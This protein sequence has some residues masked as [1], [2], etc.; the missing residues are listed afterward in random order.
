M[1]RCIYFSSAKMPPVLTSII[2]KFRRL[3]PVACAYVLRHIDILS[4]T[5]F[6]SLYHMPSKRHNAHL[7]CNLQPLDIHTVAQRS[8]QQRHQLDRSLSL[9]LSLHCEDDDP[10]ASRPDPGPRQPTLLQE[11]AS[12]DEL[13]YDVPIAC[14]RRTTNLL[15]PPSSDEL[16]CDVPAGFY[17]VPAE[18]RP[19]SRACARR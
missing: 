10:F 3:L 16:H 17:Y 19:F 1:Q 14:L 18:N 11:P 8:N 6:A 5:L 2:L 9:S 15:E 4:P 7:R 13:H 12:S